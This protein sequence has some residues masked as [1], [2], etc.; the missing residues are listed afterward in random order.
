MFHRSVENLDA[1][2]QGQLEKFTSVARKVES[3]LEVI[4]N[5]SR[6]G[7]TVHFAKLIGFSNSRTY[8]W[9]I[10]S[11]ISK[12]V[13]YHVEISWKVL[14]VRMHSASLAASK[15]C[16]VILEFQ[17]V[18]TLHYICAHSALPR[19]TWV[20][21]SAV[22]VCFSTQQASSHFARHV[23][24]AVFVVPLHYFISTLHS[25][26]K[27]DDPQP[28]VTLC[29]L[30]ESN[31]LWKVTS[32]AISCEM[33]ST[34][35]TPMFLHRPSV[36]SIQNSAVFLSRI[37]FGRWAIKDMLASPMYFQDREAN[38]DQPRVITLL[39]RLRVKLITFPIKREWTRSSLSHKWG[40][41]WLC[42]SCTSETNSLSSYG[43]W[44]H[45]PWVR[46]FSKRA[47]PAF[48]RSGATR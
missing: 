37:G 41:S 17:D 31:A 44:P 36:M 11:E 24:R 9:R 7:K 34:E 39:Q 13:W 5:T 45:Q 18:E 46:N 32:P 27:S 30:A 29:H 8:I 28:R 22:S 20:N 26:V 12:V 6:E 40:Y 3:K 47:S 1:K 16:V 48:W 35:A 43:N 21:K 25:H 38:A 33:N 10:N 42:Y 2:P 19:T 23:A 15:V 4:D 14:L